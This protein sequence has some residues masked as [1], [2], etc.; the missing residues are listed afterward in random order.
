MIFFKDTNLSELNPVY[1]SLHHESQQRY[2]HRI[3]SLLFLSIGN[4][5]V[6]FNDLRCHTFSIRVRRIIN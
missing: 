3:R 5:H 2:Y 4:D 1:S 6:S